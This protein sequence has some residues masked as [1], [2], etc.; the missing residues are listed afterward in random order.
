M[1]LP[2]VQSVQKLF[3][4]SEAE[5]KIK[6]IKKWTKWKTRQIDKERLGEKVRP[7]WKVGPSEKTKWKK[8]ED[9]YQRILA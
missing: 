9:I 2:N 6:P 8:K 4:N 7:F 1:I 5:L 3:L